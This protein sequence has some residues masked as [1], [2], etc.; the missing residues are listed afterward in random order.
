MNYCDDAG[1]DWEFF[2]I[3]VLS[4]LC[5]MLLQTRLLIQTETDKKPILDF[6]LSFFLKQKFVRVEKC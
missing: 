4:G 3:L 1:D 5:F 2:F 6:F